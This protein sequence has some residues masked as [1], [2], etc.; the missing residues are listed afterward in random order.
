MKTYLFE[1]RQGSDGMCNWG[2]FM[3]AV[4]DSE[5]EWESAVSPYRPAGN[6]F[7]AVRLLTQ[8]GWTGEHLWICDL[9]TGEGAFFR[10]GGSAGADLEKHQIWVCPLFGP[11]LEWFYAQLKERKD[12]SI[13]DIPRVA[14]LPDAP[15]SFSGYRRLGPAAGMMKAEFWKLLSTHGEEDISVISRFADSVLGAGT[16]VRWAYEYGEAMAAER[17]REQEADAAEQPPEGT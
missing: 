7:L 17:M 3:V 4:P 8:I 2:K 15:F 11:W 13:A 10:P 16:A 6:S 12:G 1:A 9:Q 14:D 5:W